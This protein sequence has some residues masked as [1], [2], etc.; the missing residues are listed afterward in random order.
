MNI[1][2][3]QQNNGRKTQNIDVHTRFPFGPS[4]HRWLE[5][6][7]MSQVEKGDE[8]LVKTK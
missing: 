2:Q 6:P 4:G 7:G 3:R 5:T 8:P 1:G